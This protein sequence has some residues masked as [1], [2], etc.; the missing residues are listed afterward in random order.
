[1]QYFQR[2]KGFNTGI[3]I[4]FAKNFYGSITRVRGIDIMVNEEVVA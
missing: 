1:M 2:L 4:E 3:A